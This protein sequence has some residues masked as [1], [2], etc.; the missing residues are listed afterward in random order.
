MN[1]RPEPTIF[2]PINA[3]MRMRIEATIELLVA[4]LDGLDGDADFEADS[5]DEDG[6]D[7]EPDV[8][9]EPQEEGGCE[10][11]DDARLLHLLLLLERAS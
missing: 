10:F 4:F 7:L 6:G 11:E 9:D 1:A 2:R 3:A 8:D 5:D